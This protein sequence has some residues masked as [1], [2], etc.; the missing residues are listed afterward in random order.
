MEGCIE[1]A[2]CPAPCVLVI[3][4]VAWW[5]YTLSSIIHCLTGSHLMHALYHTV[6]KQAFSKDQP[7]IISVITPDL[8]VV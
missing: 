6:P 1:A 5:G 2:Q 4:K 8:V 7:L 3:K